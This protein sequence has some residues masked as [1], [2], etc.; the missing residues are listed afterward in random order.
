VNKTKNIS[1]EFFGM[2]IRRIGH[3]EVSEVR[4]LMVDVVSRLP[5][6][7]FFSKNDE[8]YL[9]AHVEN[10]GEIYGA[11]L[12]GRLV[13]YTVITFPGL[14]ASNLGREFGVPE[15][16]LPR[17]ASLDATVVHES[18]RGQGLQRRFHELRE[19]RARANDC[20]YLYSTVHPD[21]HVSRQNLEAAGFLLQF[22]RPMYGGYPRHCYAKKLMK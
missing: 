7:T 16:D 11:Y 3:E 17:V 15:A 10:Q 21:N 9:H 12:D 6:H 14:E 18:A 1:L 8:D 2:E 4:K 22:T 5:S 20:L 19:Q 13:A